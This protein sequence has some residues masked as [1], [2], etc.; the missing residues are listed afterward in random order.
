MFSE[1]DER[2][3]ERCIGRDFDFERQVK[4]GL[5]TAGLRLTF[6]YRIIQDLVAEIIGDAGALY[7]AS[8]AVDFLS[9]LY[10]LMSTDFR[11]NRLR[12]ST[13]CGLLRIRL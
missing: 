12:C 4:L 3:D 11:L 8:E 1:K 9:V 10:D 7:K 5:T 2:K 13:C 6:F